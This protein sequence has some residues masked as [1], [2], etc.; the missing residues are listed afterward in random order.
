M[1]RVLC[2]GQFN[3]VE[4][5]VLSLLPSY[6]WAARKTHSLISH[7]INFTYFFSIYIPQRRFLQSAEAVTVI[8]VELTIA[9]LKPTKVGGK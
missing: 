1:Y 6:R 2:E 8:P 3:D 7:I 4:V 5:K 9:A